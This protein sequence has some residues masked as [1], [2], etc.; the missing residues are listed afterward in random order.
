[1]RLEDV[2]EAYFSA[3]KNKRKSPDQVEFELHWERNCVSLCD[4][5]NN[6]CVRPTA[7]TFVVDYPKPREVFASDMSTRIL[8]HYLDMRLR[9][10]L[11]ARMTDHT[12]NNRKGMGTNACQNAVISDIYDVSKGFTQDAYIIK[13]DMS[14]CFP[15]IIQDIAYKQI[16]EVILN[17]YE[18]DDKDDMIYIL[19]VCIFSYPT[20]HCYRKSVKSKWDNIPKEKSLFHKPDGVGGAIGHLIWQNAVNY[21][22]HDI[23]EWLLSLGICYERFVDDM[24]FVVNNKIAFLTYVIP[25]L[26]KKLHSLGAKLN[27]SKF[28]CQHYSKGVECLGVHIKMDRIYPNERVI[29]RAKEKVCQYNKCIREDKIDSVLSSINSYLGICKNTN[30]FNHALSI[31]RLLSRR[32]YKYIEFDRRRVCLV[33]RDDYKIN[34]RIVNNFYETVRERRVA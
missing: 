15:N 20:Y 1:M 7:Y 11:E 19:Q 13:L 6:R 18:G 8:H 33:A 12:F 25:I 24:Y 3:R 27:E 30:G 14:G 21:Y 4:D 17:D 9:P 2:I 16:E 32:W 26:R 22:F 34:K 31:I 10:L 29:Q 5:V 23:D 28:Y